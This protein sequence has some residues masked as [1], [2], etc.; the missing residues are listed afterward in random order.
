MIWT[1]KDINFLIEH[2]P[3]K[4]KM[5]CTKKLNRL[6]G[7]VRY[8][9]SELKLRL[10]RTSDFFYDYQHRA[11][12]SKIGKKRPEHSKLMKRYAEEGRFSILTNRTPEQNK[13]LSVKLKERIKRNGHPKGMLGKTHTKEN[14]KKLSIRSI[15]MWADKNHKVNSEGHRQMLSDRSSKLMNIRMKNNPSSIY[16]RTK[17]GKINIGGQSFFARSS[18]EANIGAYLQFLKDKK[19]IKDW[20]HEPK[21]FWFLEIKRGVRSYLPDFFVTNNNGTTYYIEVKGYMDAKSK[22]KLKRMKKYYPEI[23]LDLI[24]QKRYNEIK[25]FKNVIPDW[26]ILD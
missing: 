26:G 15:K 5:W 7:S 10:S 9:T 13:N 23:K 2:Y 25:R 4:G 6:E 11:K 21:T 24:E 3:K 17:K 14:K 18:W 19:Q 20:V 8:K 12:M 16:S 22:T 1:K